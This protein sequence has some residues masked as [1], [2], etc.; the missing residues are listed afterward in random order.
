MPF[1]FSRVTQRFI[2]NIT[3]K[4][5]I[6]RTYYDKGNRELYK[7]TL[8]A[9]GP[10]S[11]LPFSSLP[12][13]SVHY[14]SCCACFRV[15]TKTEKTKNNP[16]PYQTVTKLF[17]CLSKFSTDGCLNNNLKN[18]SVDF[19]CPVSKSSKLEFLLWFVYC[20]WVLKNQTTL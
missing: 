3:E 6:L 11:H 14:F 19:F 5:F 1:T 10:Y 18:F 16:A 15:K 12:P 2:H 20:D 13:L 7:L 4:V 8:L 17:F 9:A